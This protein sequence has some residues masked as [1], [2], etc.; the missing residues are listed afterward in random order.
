MLRAYFTSKATLAIPPPNLLWLFDKPDSVAQYDR[1]RGFLK[2]RFDALKSATG[3]DVTILFTYVGH[4]AFFGPHK[5]YCLLVKDTRAPLESDTSLRVATLARLLRGGAAE[6]SR[7]LILDCC[8]A[9]TAVSSFQGGLDQAVA[10]KADEAIQ[11][12]RGIALLCASS[13]RVPAYMDPKSSTH[14]S[15]ELVSVLRTGD[16]RTRGPLSLRQIA[17]LVQNRL[18]AAGIE[19]VARPEVHAPDQTGGDV[20]ALA[21]FPNPAAPVIP[22][23]TSAQGGLTLRILENSKPVSW[24]AGFLVDVIIQRYQHKGLRADG[25][26]LIHVDTAEPGPLI[27]RVVRGAGRARRYALAPMR[28]IAQLPAAIDIDLKDFGP[29]AWVSSPVDASVRQIHLAG[30]TPRF[31]KRNALRDFHG[32]WG[33]P[34]A[35]LTIDRTGYIL[36][37]E[38]GWRLPRWL[39]YRVC[40]GGS[41]QRPDFVSDPDLPAAERITRR[42]YSG[43][44]F[45]VGAL[46][47]SSDVTGHGQDV[48]NTTMYMSVMTPQHP[49]VNQRSWAK[50]E[51][52]TRSLAKLRPVVTISGPVFAV[53]AGEFSAT[54]FGDPPVLVPEGFFRIIVPGPPDSSTPIDPDPLTFLIPNE[55][56]HEFDLG[57]YRST[58][59]QIESL[60]GLIFFGLCTPETG[61]KL[62]QQG[63]RDMWP[64]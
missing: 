56:I 17:T 46:I 27:V 43:T 55:P 12:D 24:K 28:S 58:V 38:P 16:P 3:S 10:V 25:D 63:V 11:A 14:F 49:D 61:R 31:L 21:L 6:S 62:R 4:G 44:G 22:P 47:S 8:F 37:T 53:E 9:G 42:T 15:R 45:D 57:D 50:V 26:G 29:H 48:M 19:N 18:A 33:L 54:Q 51:S 36:G 34:A 64:V 7:I 59:A 5:E 41:G 20:A 52:Y 32:P 40:L 39:A 2:T 35:S 1:I 23:A 13:A 30:K 60:T